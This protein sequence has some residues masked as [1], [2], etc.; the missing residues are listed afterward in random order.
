VKK[1]A[2]IVP[3]LNQFEL[4]ANM[5]SSVD[6]PVHPYVIRNWDKNIGVSAAWNQGMRRAIK[7]G[8]RY[9]LI[10]NDDILFTP[11]TIE[12]L[13]D[14]AV[15]TG[16]V[17]ISPNFCIPRKHDAFFFEK[18]GMIESIHWSCIMVDM[19]QLI[20]NCGWFDENFFPAYFEDNDMFYRIH[21][22]GLKHYL[23]TD[24]GFFHRESATGESIITQ[25]NWNLCES[26][27]KYKWGGVPGEERYSFPY[28]DPSKPLS[29]WKKSVNE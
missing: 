17:I 29:Y 6:Y 7:D 14:N 1:I 21:R 13:Y 28:N 24:V 20:E 23:N 12:T 22:A 8:H 9:A 4:F 2:L 19:Y 15:D 3:V 27:Y 11:H 26:Y 16:G 5:I 18:K 25:D 10:V